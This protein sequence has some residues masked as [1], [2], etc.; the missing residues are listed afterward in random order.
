MAA[1]PKTAIGSPAHTPGFL[2]AEAANAI[3]T[4]PPAAREEAA[5]DAAVR[6]NRTIFRL[7]LGKASPLRTYLYSLTALFGV[8]ALTLTD[9][10]ATVRGLGSLSGDFVM[11][12]LD[13][14]QIVVMAGVTVALG[15]LGLV[16]TLAAMRRTRQEN[17]DVLRAA[18]DTALPPPERN[19]RIESWIEAARAEAADEVRNGPE[20]T[21]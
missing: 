11:Q 3:T 14:H 6:H 18:G 1:P 2:V 21:T 8:F 20:R 9:I 4:V 19:L 5:L 12:G 16:A 13:S 17:A 15:G 10:R 7:R